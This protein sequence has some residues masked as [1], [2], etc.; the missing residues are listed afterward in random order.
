M[1]IAIR[2][3]MIPAVAVAMSVYHVTSA[4]MITPSFFIHYPV[5]VGFV[6]VILF[7]STWGEHRTESGG[8]K[9][10]ISLIWDSFLGRV[11]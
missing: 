5:H 7:T 2:H 6:L 10:T 3:I 8:A 11:R 1:K 4:G 9:R